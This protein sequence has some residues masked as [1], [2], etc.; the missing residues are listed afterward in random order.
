MVKL[1]LVCAFLGC[2]LAA[3]DLSGHWSAGR[4]NVFTF[5]LEGERFSGKIEGRPG[6][7][8]YKIV[9]GTLNGNAISFFVLHDDQDDLEVIEN[10]GKPF[11]NTASGVVEGDEITISGSREGSSQRAY[12]LVLKRIRGPELEIIELR[13]NF[14]V[15]AGAGANISVQSGPDGVIL[16]DA[17]SAA[18]PDQV[19]AA[20]QKLSARPIRFII[21]TSADADHVG[22]NAR[23]AAA[24]ESLTPASRSLLPGEATILA[25]EHVLDRMSAPTGKQSPFPTAAWPTETYFRNEKPMFLNHEGI[26]VRFQPAAHSDGDSI[27]FFRRSDIVA[28]GDLIDSEHFPLIDVEQGGSIQGEIEALNH[29]VEMAIPSTPL[30]G[31]DA[32]TYVVPGHGRIM[33]QADVVEYRDMVTIV[34]DVVQDLMNKHQTLDEIKQADPAKG[35]EKRYGGDGPQSADHFVEAIFVSL[36]KKQ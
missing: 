27:V 16:V 7:R 24:G 23:I 20:V 18:M 17:G 36:S 25:H 4:S 5:Q 35:Y 1:V 31:Q 28:A 3:A 13:P 14:H 12:K 32:G 10:G 30:L 26:E 15:I 22:G 34:R 29:L 8:S 11:R 6:D 33:D 2:S 9:D 21:N 19:L